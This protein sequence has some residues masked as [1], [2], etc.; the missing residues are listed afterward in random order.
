MTESQSIFEY[1]VDTVFTS[2]FALTAIFLY[3]LPALALTSLLTPAPDNWQYVLG[4]VVVTWSLYT[5]QRTL[6]SDVPE[7]HYD[8]TLRKRLNRW[9]NVTY[10]NAVILIAGVVGISLMATF[11]VPDGGVLFAVS[12][13]VLH[14]EFVRRSPW[15]SPIIAGISAFYTRL[16]VFLEQVSDEDISQT[17]WGAVPSLDAWTTRYRNRKAS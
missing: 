15:P 11:D 12:F 1:T 2:I 6:N 13:P 16:A 14:H 10:H 5:A 3:T 9:A 4:L 17:T 7:D 8:S